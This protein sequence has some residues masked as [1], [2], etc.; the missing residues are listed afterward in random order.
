MVAADLHVIEAPGLGRGGRGEVGWTGPRYAVGDDELGFDG[1]NLTENNTS[2]LMFEGSD[3]LRFK[4]P[5][6]FVSV[7]LTNA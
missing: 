4:K 6:D 2:W 5:F 7:A 1:K 3:G